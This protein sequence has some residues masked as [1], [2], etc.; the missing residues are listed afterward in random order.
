MSRRPA[1]RSIVATTLWALLFGLAAVAGASAQADRKQVTH[2]GV[3]LVAVKPS[4]EVLNKADV[5]LPGP[6]PALKKLGAAIDLIRRTSPYST[7]AIETLRAAGRVTVVY[8]PGFEGKRV[9]NFAVAAFFP[10]YFK[11]GGGGAKD[12]LVVIGPHGVK[13][14]PT[15]LAM[16]MVHELVGH[17][18]QKLRGHT[19][20]IRELDLECAANLYGERFYQDAGVDKKDSD[21]VD[22][23][24]SLE[25]LW[26]SDFK[27]YMRQYAAASMPLWDVLD[28]DVPKLLALFDRY[29]AHLRSSGVSGKAIAAAKTMQEDKFARALKRVADEGTPEERYRMGVRYRDGVGTE[30]SPERAVIWFRQAAEKGHAMARLALGAAYQK[31]AG[32]D[33]DMAQAAAWYQKAAADDLAPAQ[34]ALGFLHERGLGVPRDLDKATK[35]YH[36]AAR[37]GD[38]VGLFNL[39][40]LYKSGAADMA[41][42]SVMAAGLLRKSAEGG[43][44]PAR[45]TLGTM[46][47]KGEGVTK[48]DAEATRWYRM[49]AEQGQAEAQW[50]FGV[51]LSRGRG[52]EEDGEAALEWFRKAALQ[53]H[54]GGAAAVAAHYAKGE[55]VEQNLEIAAGWYRKAADQGHIGAQYAMGKIYRDGLGGLPEDQVEAYFWLSLVAERASG[56]RQGK[57]NA[58]RARIARKLSP[59]QVEA[60]ME[61]V[62]AWKPATGDMVAASGG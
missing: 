22:F 7:K 62:K 41:K 51:M 29:V 3:I 27:A 57:A 13:W 5:T 38:V 36:A 37:K 23:R 1:I 14:P 45:L 18:M 17:G 42:D 55:V 21:I 19:D 28:P 54:A 24:Q 8:D 11:K 2:K 20:T 56:R 30:P 25:E 32:V 43:F 60:V 44:A 16:V 48:D 15:Q 52:V 6:D 4:A 53:G 46:Y 31:G 61:R 39:G 26:C 34:A 50:S 49:A 12:F 9:G 35:L 59:A 47:R 10:D 33:T 40:I 58:R